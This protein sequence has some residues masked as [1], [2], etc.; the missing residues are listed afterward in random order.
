MSDHVTMEF[1]DLKHAQNDKDHAE[2]KTMLAAIDEAVR[3]NGKPGIR[4]SV[5]RH[6]RILSVLL[7]GV[8]VIVVA[9]IGVIVPVGMKLLA[10]GVR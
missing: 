7:W 2:I 6:E 1:C 8:G 4:A 9:V 5:D 3:G 10:S